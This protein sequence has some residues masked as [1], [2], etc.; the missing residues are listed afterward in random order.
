VWKCV[1]KK[2]S[3]REYHY[4]KLYDHVIEFRKGIMLSKPIK[5]YLLFLAER[6][7]LYRWIDE[8]LRKVL[9]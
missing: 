3:Q 6:N 1:L 5:V 9:K 4:R 2:P 8:E 7:S